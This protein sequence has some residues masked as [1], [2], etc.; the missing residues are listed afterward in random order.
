[1]LK[2]KILSIFLLL[3]CLVPAITEA[4]VEIQNPLEAGSISELIK[5]II[6]FIFYIG[7]AITPIMI[8]VAAFHFL[9]AAGDPKKV[10]Q[11]K[12]ILLYTLIGLAILLVAKAIPEVLREILEPIDK[13]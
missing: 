11:A 3:L 4:Q 13:T 5:R 8:V 1:M 2:K 10:S 6:D 12:K 7:V 9:T